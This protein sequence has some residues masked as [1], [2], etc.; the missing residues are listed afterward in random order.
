MTEL[1]ST[2]RVFNEADL[3]PQPGTHPN[4]TGKDMIGGENCP[5]ERIHVKLMSFVAGAKA[6]LHWHPTE[7]FYY[8]ISGKAVVTDIE[9]KTYDVGPGTGIFYP[10][11]IKASHQWEVIEPMQLITVRATNNPAK[12]IQFRVDKSTMESS[13]ELDRL[14]RHNAVEFKSIY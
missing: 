6:P 1:K 3:A 13:I 4:Q 7:A 9:G 11:G 14:I 10:P 12:L 5:S 2:L 8:C